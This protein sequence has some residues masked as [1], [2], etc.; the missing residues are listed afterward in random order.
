MSPPVERGAAPVDGAVM[1]GADEHQVVERIVPA[2]AQPPDVVS[3]AE[4]LAVLVDGIPPADL[5]VAVVQ[6]LETIHEIW[7]AL[8]SFLVQ[9][10]LPLLGHARLFVADEPLHGS[11]VA[12]DEGRLQLLLGQNAGSRLTRKVAGCL[13]ENSMI[14]F[15]NLSDGGVTLERAP[16]HSG[17]CAD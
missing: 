14:L 10:P 13:P 4:R 8:R 2:A 17:L 3:L 6:A 5:T 1:V 9:V 15:G 16:E 7:I 11:A 12:H